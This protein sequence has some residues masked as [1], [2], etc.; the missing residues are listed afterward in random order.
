[1]TE[2]RT[3]RNVLALITENSQLARAVPLL[4]PEVLHAV[5]LHYGLQDSADLLA[6]TTS[7]QLSAVFDLDLWKPDR[8]GADEHFDA[9]R[10][11]EWLEVLVDSSPTMAADRLAKMDA[12]LIV[13]GLSPNVKVFD[14]GTFEPTEEPSSADAV[15][16]PGRERGVHAEIGGYV[17]VARRQDVWDPILDVLNALEERDPDAFHRIMRGCRKLSNSGREFDGLDELLSDANQTRF[18]LSASREQRR[19]RMGFLPAP[20]ARAFLDSARHTLLSSG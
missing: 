16:N 19:E 10:F 5:I 8:A 2:D 3:P 9:A 18:D 13:A 4:R 6:L 14:P 12:A 15:L 7:E 11:C 20:E 17:I 1:M